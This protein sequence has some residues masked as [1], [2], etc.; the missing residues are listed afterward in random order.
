MGDAGAQWVVE[1]RDVRKDYRGLRPLRVKHLQLRNGQA[2]AL[3]GFDEIAAEVLVNLITGATVPDEGDVS[4]FG[5]ST[6]ALPDGDAWLASLDRFGILSARAVLLDEIT[7]EQNLALPF[8]L[9]LD[10]IPDPVRTQVRDLAAEVGLNPP[11]LVRSPATLPPLDRLRLRLAR[12]VA[13]SPH[14][15]LAEHPNAYVPAED[16]PLF[17]TDYARVVTR[18]GIASLVITAD[19]TFA[20]AVAEQVLTLQPATGELKPASLWQRWLT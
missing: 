20:A 12:A 4:I 17:A 3:L 10:P 6:A 9:E 7:V 8:T 13:L 16:V 14:L 19:R 11:D 5:E 2:L 1:L 15:L 18:R